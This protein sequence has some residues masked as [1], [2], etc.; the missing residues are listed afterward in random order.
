MILRLLRFDKRD[1]RVMSDKL[2]S[3]K[4][5]WNRWVLLLPLML[6]QSQRRQRMSIFYLSE[7]NFLS[8]KHADSWAGGVARKPDSHSDGNRV[9]LLHV[10][11]LHVCRLGFRDVVH[12]L[13]W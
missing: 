2:A 13:A 3:I 10:W 8:A 12:Y 9:R 11:R 7:E 5:V 6:N 4:N 1:T